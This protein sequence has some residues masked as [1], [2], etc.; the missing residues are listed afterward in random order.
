MA[1]AQSPGLLAK[2]VFI[3]GLIGLAALPVGALG[4]RF[5]LW[6]VDTGSA[7]VFSGIVLATIVL[8][9]GIA[10]LVF[11]RMRPRPVERT[12][13]LIGLAASVLVL[14]LMGAQYAKAVTMPLI[15]DVATDRD[16]P[17]AFEHLAVSSVPG[18]NLLQYTEEEAR[19]QSEGYPDL[20]GIQVADSVGE[21]FAKAIALARALGWEVVNEDAG[22]GLIEATDTTFWFGHTDD[23]A[24]RVREVGNETVVDL[25]S[26]SRVGLADLGTNAERIQTYL[27][28]WDD[29]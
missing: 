2:F 16:D 18:A 10:T 17:P 20:A 9:L 29:L 26:V 13:A 6:G 14:G 4:H 22:A 8:V 11:A 24:I 25:R 3:V 19:V 23:V 12:P 21:S 27:D 28:R 5:G 7:L 15:N 1:A